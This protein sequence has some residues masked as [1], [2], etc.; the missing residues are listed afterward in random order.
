VQHGKKREGLERGRLAKEP[1]RWRPPYAARDGK[2]RVGKLQKKTVRT[3]HYPSF[4][5]KRKGVLNGLP[6]PFHPNPK[7]K[8][9]T[10]ESLGVIRA[11]N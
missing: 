9:E 11:H 4:S 7:P 6:P 10:M 5:K 1:G 2:E 3:L 8:P